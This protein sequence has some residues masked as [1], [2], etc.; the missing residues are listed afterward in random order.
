MQFQTPPLAA[1]GVERYERSV[2][3]AL[4]LALSFSTVSPA[5]AGCAASNGVSTTTTTAADAKSGVEIWAEGKAA[6][7]AQSLK[8]APA[9]PFDPFAV[10]KEAEET[11]IP[12]TEITPRH[13]LRAKSGRERE[14]AIDAA[15]KTT[16][17]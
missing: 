12:R 15:R 3:A 9:R 10:N 13:D 4:V 14:L 5:V 1:A 11:A 8:L 2:K 7:E 16:R 6:A 17:S